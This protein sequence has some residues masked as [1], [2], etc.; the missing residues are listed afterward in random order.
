MIF[1]MGSGGV[2][3]KYNKDAEIITPG[4]SNQVV[5][6]GTYLRG[7]LIILGDENLI[8]ANIP[9]DVNIFG[10]QGTRQPDYGSNVWLKSNKSVS[11]STSS[12]SAYQLFLNNKIT[13][14]TSNITVYYST[15]YELSIDGVYTLVNPTTYSGTIANLCSGQVLTGKYI[16][17]G[18]KDGN[19]QSGSKLIKINSYN[20]G[21]GK[22]GDGYIYDYARITIYT[23]TA[24]SEPLSYVVND[25]SSAYPGGGFHTDGYYYE[26]L[27]QVSSANVM[28]LSDDALATVQSDY[29]EQIT[30]EVSES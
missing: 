30:T 25:D 15:D 9:S 27:G 24:T 3:P 29:R 2:V 6:L 22:N 19:A 7:D 1:N 13:S 26:L 8:P 5:P 20:T 12:N 4:T 17:C 10:V 14:T 11:E 16:I 18:S 28:S 23:P 21:P